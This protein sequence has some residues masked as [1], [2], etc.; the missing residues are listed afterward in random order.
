ARIGDQPVRDAHGAELVRGEACALEQRARLVDPDELDAVG[1]PGGLDRAERGAP[2]AG[3]QGAGVAVRQHALAP[4][5][6]RGT[7]DG[8]ATDRVSHFSGARAADPGL[9]RG[10]SRLI[11]DLERAVAPAKR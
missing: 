11:E 9:L 3:R 8:E 10:K 1:L 6:E 5:E 4:A 2:S 7:V